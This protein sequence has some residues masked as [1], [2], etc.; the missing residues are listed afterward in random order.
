MYYSLILAVQHFFSNSH[1][2]DTVEIF[3]NYRTKKKNASP[4]KNKTKQKQIEETKKKK[5]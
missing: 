3:L 5:T 4:Q 1:N 2:F